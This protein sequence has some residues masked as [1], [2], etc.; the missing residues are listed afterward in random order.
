MTVSV[1]L[2]F[3]NED[4]AIHHIVKQLQRSKLVFE[5]IIVDDGSRLPLKP[6]SGTRIIRHFSNQGK[7]Q[8]LKTGLLASSGQ[9]V[10]FLDSDLQ[11]FSHEH[12]CQLVAPI[13]SQQFDLVI[14]EYHEDFWP[15]QLI[16]QTAAFSGQRAFSRQFLDTNLDLFDN[17]GH[18]QGYLI[19][20]LMNQR[21]FNY[22]RITKV[23][24]VNL[25]NTYKFKKHGPIS[26]FFDDS[27]MLL[28]YLRTLGP[29]QYYCQLSYAKHLP[30]FS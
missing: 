28:H 10:V 25:R 21:F 14:G 26:G 27:K 2:P 16:G 12:L 13:I 15:F 7:S 6:I 9:I 4:L 5:I 3:F 20:P 29:H 23:R 24:L 1:I 19:E 22:L 18:T 8:A 11:N 30:Y 17:V